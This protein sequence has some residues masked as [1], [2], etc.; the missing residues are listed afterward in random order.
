M[1]APV[2]S[3]VPSTSPRTTVEPIL[4]LSP[5]YIVTGRDS[6]IKAAWSTSIFP[7]ITLQS[8]GM[9]FPDLR[10]IKSPGTTKEAPSLTIFPSLLTVASGF[11]D[12]FRAMRLLSPFV[13]YR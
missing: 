1:F 3:T 9:I 2:N 8:A 5:W 12:D 7:L 13:F 4:Q 11:K 6:P 10:R